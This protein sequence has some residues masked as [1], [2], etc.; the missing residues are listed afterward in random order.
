MALCPRTEGKALLVCGN[1]RP[2]VKTTVF[3]QVVPVETAIAS[4]GFGAV[5]QELYMDAQKFSAPFNVRAVERRSE[6]IALTGHT[7]EALKIDKEGGWRFMA[8]SATGGFNAS[9]VAKR[10]GK[11]NNDILE[12]SQRKGSR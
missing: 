12:L 4:G 2:S 3:V 8:E 6:R 10:K 9:A 7:F 11:S 5:V 1:L